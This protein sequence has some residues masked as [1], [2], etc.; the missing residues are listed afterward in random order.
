M[1]GEEVH[2]FPALPLVDGMLHPFKETGTFDGHRHLLG[3]L[4][5]HTAQ[6]GSV[7]PLLRILL[8]TSL[9]GFV[10]CLRQV[11]AGAPETLEHHARRTLEQFSR[12]LT[13]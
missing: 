8:E 10:Q 11:G 9:Q 2:A 6:T 3:G 13:A 1:L 4:F 5:Q 12:L 7:R